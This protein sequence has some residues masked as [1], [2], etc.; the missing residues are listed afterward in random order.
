MD[1][2]EWI[3]EWVGLESR[4]RAKGD[5]IE[6]LERYRFIGDGTFYR[7]GRPQRTPVQDRCRINPGEASHHRSQIRHSLGCGGVGPCI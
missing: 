1:R 4:L 7:D 2:H 3:V 5:R 6:V